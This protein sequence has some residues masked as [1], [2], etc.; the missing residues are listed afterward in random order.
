MALANNTV[1][2]YAK[3]HAADELVGLGD[4]LAS[5]DNINYYLDYLATMTGVLQVF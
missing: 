4:N 1:N 3:E 5:L 2:S